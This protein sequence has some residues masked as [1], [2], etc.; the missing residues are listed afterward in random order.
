MAVG[1]SF[2]GRCRY[3]EVNKREYRLS[4]GTEKSGHCGEVVIGGGFTVIYLIVL[5]FLILRLV[6]WK[7]F[8]F[9]RTKKQADKKAMV[10]SSFRMKSL[11]L[12][13]LV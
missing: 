7:L 9:Q 3:G 2:V 1:T 11:H 5:C 12:I 8:T 10:L 13:P 4:A 6:L